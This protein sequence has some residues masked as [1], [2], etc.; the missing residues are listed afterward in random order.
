[1]KVQIY[2]IQTPEEALLCLNAGADRIGVAAGAEKYAIPANVA[3]ETAQ[4]IFTAVRGK[5]EVSLLSVADDPEEI[6]PLL[7][8][9]QP[10]VI[11]ICG[12]RFYATEAFAE[13]ARSLVPGIRVLQAVPV[14]G[15]EAVPLALALSSF[16]DELILDSVA[17]S[18]A[19]IGA[20]GVTHDW[21][22][23]KAIV[24]AL[25]GSSCKV[26]LAGGLGPDN[27][28]EAIRF[29]RPQGVDSFTRTSVFLPNGKSRKDRELTERFVE[30][31]KAAGKELGL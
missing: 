9:L 5:M 1:M 17:P 6:Y 15:K 14:A 23:S 4:K 26:I 7:P 8:L 18:I 13:K 2:S 16:C 25:R 10:G 29:V 31:A 3:L 21:N 20:A 19:G 30:E 24:D 11:H 27:V 22:V 12:S 28:R